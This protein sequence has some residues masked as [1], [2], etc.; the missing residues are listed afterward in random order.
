MGCGG[1]QVM[2]LTKSTYSDTFHGGPEPPDQN[3]KISEAWRRDKDDGTRVSQSG[4]TPP[5]LCSAVPKPSLLEGPQD[6]TWP[7]RKVLR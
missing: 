6:P 5:A 1:E 3:W 2:N 7:A 4:L